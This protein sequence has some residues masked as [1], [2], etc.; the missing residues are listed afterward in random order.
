MTKSLKT[1]AKTKNENKLHNQEDVLQLTEKL[2]IS[3]VLHNKP[4]GPGH[5]K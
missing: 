1:T 2:S 3:K 4:G 5:C